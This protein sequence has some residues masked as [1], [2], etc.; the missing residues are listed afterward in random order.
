MDGPTALVIAR[1][2][3]SHA[4]AWG[5]A[6]ND[7]RDACGDRNER[8]HIEVSAVPGYVEELRWETRVC[9]IC[10]TAAHRKAATADS[11]LRGRNHCGA[12]TGECKHSTIELVN[13]VMDMGWGSGTAAAAGRPVPAMIKTIKTIEK[14]LQKF[15]TVALLT[16]DFEFGL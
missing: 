9:Q 7:E 1:V 14:A 16:V 12:S 4:T 8:S 5:L 15:T 11:V 13:V 10:R 6:P 3:R 2:A